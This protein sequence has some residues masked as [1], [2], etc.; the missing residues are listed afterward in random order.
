M[1]EDLKRL[2]IDASCVSRSR[3]H[4][5][6]GTVIIN[7]TGE[8]RR[9]IHCIGANADFSFSDIDLLA[10]NGAKALYVGGYMAMPPSDMDRLDLPD[11]ARVFLNDAVA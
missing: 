7:V 10:L 9:Y 2:G 5:T 4:L 11:I 8:D 1:I 3:V 6:S